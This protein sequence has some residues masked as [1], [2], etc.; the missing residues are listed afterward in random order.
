MEKLKTFTYPK[1][2]IQ[3][4]NDETGYRTYDVADVNDAISLPSVTTILGNTKDK[5]FLD[6]WKKKVGEEQARKIVQDASARGTSMH[7]QIEGWISGENHADLT[8]AG[9]EAESMAKTIIKNGLEGRIEG[10]YGIEALMYYPNLYAGSADLI[11]QHEGELTVVDF[12]QTNKPKQEAW[13]EDYFMQLAA[14]SMAHDFVYKTEIDKA[15]IMMCSV[16][17][18]YQE[19]IISG[20]Q[21]RDWKHKFLARVDQYYGQIDQGL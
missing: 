18:Y 16:D 1:S 4:N 15:M 7:H 20:A 2:F 12:K 21:L 10:Y 6:T 5:S 13:I 19:W 11:C 14:Y 9:K 17:N 8:P 3:N